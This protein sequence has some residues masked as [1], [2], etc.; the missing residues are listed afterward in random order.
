MKGRGA[1]GL[2]VAKCKADYVAYVKLILSMDAAEA[3]QHIVSTE[4][5]AHTLEVCTNGNGI[6][7]LT[8]GQ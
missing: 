4:L 1:G 6:T 7:A 5:I 8:A 2:V 3:R